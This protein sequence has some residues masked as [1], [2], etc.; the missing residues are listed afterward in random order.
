MGRRAV[1]NATPRL[2]DA[3]L[4]EAVAS[5]R[6]RPGPGPGPASQAEALEAAA[7]RLALLTGAAIRI[8]H[9]EL[10]LTCLP[11]RFVGTLRVLR[12]DESFEQ[13]IDLDVR[14]T[15]D[16]RLVVLHLLSLSRNLRLRVRALFRG[17]VAPSAGA[18]Y[19]GAGFQEGL[20]SGLTFVSPAC[21]PVTGRMT[22]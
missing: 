19:P 22:Q 8:A 13:L 15:P 14:W 5:D 16:G 1:S 2:R 20:S 10:T 17:P 3:A 11:E 9:G 4:K 7:A 6:S 18:V 12:S 21:A